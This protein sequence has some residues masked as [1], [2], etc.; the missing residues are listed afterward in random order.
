MARFLGHTVI[1]D[2]HMGDWGLQMGTVITEL[3]RRKPDLPYFDEN[4][5]GE[6]PEEAPFTISEL[7]EIYPA[8]S[9]LTKAIRLPWKKQELLLMNFSMEEEA[10]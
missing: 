10:M 3:R 7:E 9:K 4:Y 1:G 8:G 5:E 2:I 6:Y